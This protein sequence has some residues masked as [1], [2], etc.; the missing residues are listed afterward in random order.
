[1]K[2]NKLTA[3]SARELESTPGGMDG[4]TALAIG[5]GA[6]AISLGV[7]C[8]PVAGVALVCWLAGAVGVIGDG[9]VM[10]G[11]ASSS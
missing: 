9:Y 8:A 2:E 11:V 1:M 7:L 3:L 10:Y 6:V 5:G 4:A